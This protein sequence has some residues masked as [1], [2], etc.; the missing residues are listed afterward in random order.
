MTMTSSEYQGHSA[1][2]TNR[3][4]VLTQEQFGV[5]CGLVQES[6]DVEVNGIAA[7]KHA[8]DA[9]RQKFPLAE[10]RRLVG[11]GVID[12][13]PDEDEGHG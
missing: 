10:F 2:T 12:Y 9:L 6:T 13:L 1:T 4:V 5:L 3:Y 8:W 11:E 7:G